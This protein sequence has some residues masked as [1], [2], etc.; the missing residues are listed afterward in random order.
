MKNGDWFLI[1]S[2]EVAD[3]RS[4]PQ[5]NN[6]SWALKA[7]EG[8]GHIIDTILCSRLNDSGFEAKGIVGEHMIFFSS[9]PSVFHEE[10]LGENESI[11]YAYLPPQRTLL[12]N[13]R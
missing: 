2:R 12:K 9:Q 5:P 13:E 8:N 1:P 3:G 11:F 10:R 4:L 7:P 6:L